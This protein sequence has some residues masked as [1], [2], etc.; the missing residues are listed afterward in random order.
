[1][2]EHK[3][4]WLFEQNYHNL[5][6]PFSYIVDSILMGFV[7]SQSYDVGYITFIQSILQT[8]LYSHA[9]TSETRIRHFTINQEL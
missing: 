5:T 9:W 4:I 2:T 7:L 6:I 8:F 1:M 3:I